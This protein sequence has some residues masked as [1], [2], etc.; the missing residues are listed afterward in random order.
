MGLRSAETT[1]EF[2]LRGGVER[3]AGIGHIQTARD[4]GQSLQH[5]RFVCSLW[6]TADSFNVV[7]VRIEY[8]S[9][10]VV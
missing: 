9:S 7:T 8:E 3:A 2:W 5:A 6:L 4:N 10:V 1:N